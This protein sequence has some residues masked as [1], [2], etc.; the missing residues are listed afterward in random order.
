MAYT[1]RRRKEQD[2]A[3]HRDGFGLMVTSTPPCLGGG[4]RTRSPGTILPRISTI[5]ILHVRFVRDNNGQALA[6]VYFENEPG[7]R[8]AANLLT[9]DGAGRNEAARRLTSIPGI[10]APNATALVAAVGDTKTFARGRD[11]AAWLGLMPRQ[12]T[13][14]GNRVCLASP[15]VAAN[16]C[17]RC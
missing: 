7:R 3:V 6:Y 1:G 10:G 9:R 12:A 13:T 11:L 8:T 15:N 5:A 16:T 14:G 17:A 4:T 2:I